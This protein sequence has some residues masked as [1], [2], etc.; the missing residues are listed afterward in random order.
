MML[1]MH[2]RFYNVVSDGRPKPHA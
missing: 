2:Y 1:I